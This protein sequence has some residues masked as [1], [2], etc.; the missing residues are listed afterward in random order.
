MRFE[1]LT[2]KKFG[3]L[4]VV[5]RAASIIQANGR[6]RVAWLCRCDCG[7]TCTVQADVLKRGGVK[8]CGCLKAEHNRATW[9]KHN[10]SRDRLY[11]VWTDIKKRCYNPK[12]K[13]YKDYGGRGIRMCNEWLHDYSAF[14]E[15]ALK[16][17]YD[18]DAKFG[19]TT[20]D[21]IDVNGNYCPENCRFVDMK[22]Q[23]NNQRRSL[24]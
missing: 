15:F 24:K 12:F 21:R 9:T 22:I 18:P 2:G 6:K 10:G 7:H 13:Q 16:N 8:S 5:E 14:R 19:E 20:I 1:N 11:G 23:A 3:R 4:A 17:G